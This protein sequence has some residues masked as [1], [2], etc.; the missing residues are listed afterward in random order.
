M[1]QPIQTLVTVVAMAV[2]SVT[3]AAAAASESPVNSPVSVT[4]IAPERFADAGNRRFDEP[5]NLKQLEQTLQAL[6]TKLLPPGHTMHIDVLD[7]DL[8]GEMRPGRM[9]NDLRVLKGAADWPR[10]TM[11]YTVES[12]GQVLRSGE[13]NV[14]DLN[15]LGHGSIRST[16]EPLRHEKQMLADWFEAQFGAR[17]VARP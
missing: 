14:V 13:A 15:Y 17:S 8:A 6:G 7:V 11:R 4:F 9:L 3:T 16:N 12:G 10:I 2:A 5:G 1:N